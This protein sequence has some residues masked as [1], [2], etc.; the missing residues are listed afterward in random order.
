MSDATSIE[1]SATRDHKGTAIPV[2]GEYVLDTAHTTIE[3]V[4]RHLMIAKV[5]G[6][7]TKFEG[8][9]KIAD[10]PEDS[11]IEISVDAASID[12]SE[13]NRD[14]H[15]RSGDFLE[16]DKFPK[17]TFKS[18]K[19]EHRGDTNWKLS[20]DLTIHGVTKPIVFDVEFLGVTVSPWGTKPFGFEAIA[21]ID[22]EDWGLTWNQ[23]L[24]TGGVVVGKKVRV[25]INVELL[26]KP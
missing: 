13:P 9:V 17:V 11:S 4:A 22:R 6:R 15:L 7:F 18:T 8:S 19:I 14:A 5:R 20:G 1:A 23:A 25:E 26:A 24:E 3:F 12:T 10:D 16:T 2:P 21:E